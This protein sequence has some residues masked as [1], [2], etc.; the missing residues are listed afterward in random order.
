MYFNRD[1]DFK[2]SF[3]SSRSFIKIVFGIVIIAIIA[4][5]AFYGFIVTKTVQVV[6][7]NNGSI[8]TTMGHFYKDFKQAAGE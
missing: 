7:E 1:K 4:Q 2:K 8:A 6:N 5:F 3:N